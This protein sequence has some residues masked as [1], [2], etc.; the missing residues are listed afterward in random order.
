MEQKYDDCDKM[1]MDEDEG[2]KMRKTNDYE[3][4]R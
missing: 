3:G 4:E 1:V 2:Q